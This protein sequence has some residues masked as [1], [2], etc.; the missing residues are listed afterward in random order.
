MKSKLFITIVAATSLMVGLLML[1][2]TIATQATTTSVVTTS[3]GSALYLPFISKGYRTL[4]S[5]QNLSGHEVV[6]ECNPGGGSSCPCS[7]QDVA[8]QAFD[9]YGEVVANPQQQHTWVNAIG[10]KKFVEAFPDTTPITLGIYS[11]RGRVS[12]PTIP[13]PN[14]DQTENAE[15]VHMMIQ[16]WDGRNALFQSNKTTLEGAI[17]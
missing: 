1:S 10:H 15:A 5:S 7:E 12:L 11:Y 16:L 3:L 2:S 4:Y 6:S 8:L 9:D 17:Y 14:V 13:F